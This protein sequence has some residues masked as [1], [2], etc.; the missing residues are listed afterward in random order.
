[1]T[2]LDLSPAPG[3]ASRARRLRA[4]TAMELR[5]TVRNGEQMVVTFVI[6]L[7]LL[8]VGSRSDR[9]IDSDRPLDVLAPG[10]LGLA[11]VSTSFTSLAIATAFE[12]RYGVLKRLGATPLSRSGLLGGKV[13]A[14][15]ILQVAQFAVLGGLAV[16]LGWRPEE[17][18]AGVVWLLVLGL[19]GTIAF[20]GLGLLLAGT[21][22]AEATLAL[23]NLIYVLLL[24]GGGLLLPLDRHPE[25]ARGLVTLLPSGALGEGLREAFATGSPGTF[26]VVVLAVWAV[27]AAA[28]AGRWFRWE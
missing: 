1:M 19:L 23:A 8:I 16:A 10:V 22:R 17:P 24:V 13:G 21:L 28:A 7:L 18:V 27:V 6:P 12:R 11:I 14:V 15:A 20:G 4:Q 5:L 26:V 25:A 3:A 2:S 9:F